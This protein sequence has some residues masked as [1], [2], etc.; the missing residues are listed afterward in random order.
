VLPHPL[1]QPDITSLWLTASLLAGLTQDPNALVIGDAVTPAKV[2][3]FSTVQDCIT[4]CDYDGARC[5]G[6]TLEMTVDRL[7]IA[8]TCKLI[9]GNAMPGRFKR[10]VVRTELDRVGFPTSFLW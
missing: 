4:A 10:T 6:V 3:T 2:S 7:K 9:R 1:P 8:S 5:V